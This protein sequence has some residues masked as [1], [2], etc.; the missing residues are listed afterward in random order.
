METKGKI[1]MMT[2]EQLKEK[3]IGKNGTKKGDKYEF[4]LKVEVLGEMIKSTRKERN[5]TQ[6]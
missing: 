2:L 4:D 1:E 5:L 3:H 6:K